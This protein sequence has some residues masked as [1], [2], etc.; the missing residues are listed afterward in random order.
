VEEQV[1]NIYP[2]QF[3]LRKLQVVVTGRVWDGKVKKGFVLVFEV[4]KKL[5][6]NRGLL[7]Q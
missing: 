2:S 3:R 5:E 6:W 4:V 1:D 7:S